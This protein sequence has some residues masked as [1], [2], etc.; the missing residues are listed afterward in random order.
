MTGRSRGRA[1]SSAG[2]HVHPPAPLTT[3]KVLGGGADIRS[4]GQLA[5]FA[6][7]WTGAPPLPATT[8]CRGFHWSWVSDP[9]PLSLPSTTQTPT[10]PLR[11]HPRL[12]PQGWGRSSSPST[13]FSLPFVRGSSSRQQTSPSHHR[14]VPTK[15]VCLRPPHSVSTITQ[16]WRGF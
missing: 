16:F 11:P 6:A 2:L 10:R 5:R 15:S 13:L 4:G 8:V 3:P 7:K 1:G 14:F 9:P 12:G